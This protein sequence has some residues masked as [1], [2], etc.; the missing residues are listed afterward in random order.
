[1]NARRAPLRRAASSAPA[2]T[3]A[4][5]AG[6][7]TARCCSSPTRWAPPARTTSE[8]AVTSSSSPGPSTRSGSAG[9]PFFEHRFHS[10]RRASNRSS[11]RRRARTSPVSLHRA[12]V[13]ESCRSTATAAPLSTVLPP[14]RATS[15]ETGMRSWA[16]ALSSTR[17]PSETDRDGSKP[18]SSGGIRLP[19]PPLT[20]IRKDVGFFLSVPSTVPSRRNITG[21]SVHLQWPARSTLRRVPIC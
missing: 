13:N 10:S 8:R 19:A 18:I 11:S 4:R 1:M 6:L 2:S 3:A 14:D 15:I 21:D 7:S 9:V 5:S 12:S 16:A 20:N 17:G